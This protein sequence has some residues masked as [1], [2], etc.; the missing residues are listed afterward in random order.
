MEEPLLKKEKEQTKKKLTFR[1]KFL[2]GVAEFGL[3]LIGVIEG[4][5]LQT[6]FLEVAEIS[7]SEVRSLGFQCKHRN[8]YDE[9]VFTYI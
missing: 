6:F 8:V 4:F 1:V 2:Y 5:F 7:T 3:F 9:S